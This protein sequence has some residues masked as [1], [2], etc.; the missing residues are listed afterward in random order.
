MECW[1][2]CCDEVED[3]GDGAFESLVDDGDE[4]CGG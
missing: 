1:M 3:V 4:D 2:G